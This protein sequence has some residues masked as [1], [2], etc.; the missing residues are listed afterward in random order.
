MIFR[1]IPSFDDA[2]NSFNKKRNE[3]NDIRQVIAFNHDKKR[4][5][6]EL[7]VLDDEGW[8]QRFRNAK[9]ALMPEMQDLHTQRVIKRDLVNEY[10]RL[11]GRTG[12]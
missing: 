6:K 5:A 11:T 7:A 8:R 9:G 2:R 1:Q 10:D 12:R 3:L 4:A